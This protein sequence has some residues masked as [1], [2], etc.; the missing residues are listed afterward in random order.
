MNLFDLK[1]PQVIKQMNLKELQLLASEIRSFLLLN[2]PKTGGHLS[3]NLGVVELTIALHFVFDSPVD[4]IIFDV[5]HQ[6]YTHKI[7]TGRASLFETLRQMD[8]LSGFINYQESIHDQWESGHAGTAISAMTGVLMANYQQ[9][10]HTSVVAL[11]GDA[12]ISNGTAFEALNFLGSQKQYKGIIVLN[13]NEMSISKNVGSFS[14]LFARIRN[15][16]WYQGTKKTLG[17]ITPRFLDRFIFQT[18]RAVKSFFQKANIFEDL[19]YMYLGPVDGHNL[20]KLIA[21]LKRAKK[22]KKSVVL[23]V[24][25]EKG[26][27]HEKAEID[28]VGVFHGI[29]KPKEKV[30]SMISW[31]KAI[32]MILDELQQKYKINVIMPAMTVGAEFVEFAQKYPDRFVDVGIA[33]GHAAVFAASLAKQKEHVFLP[34]YATFAQRAFDQI[35]ND[36]A[37]PN[38]PV[39]IGIDRAGLVGEDGSTHQG[40]YD[41]SMFNL[42]P[43]IKIASPKSMQEAANIIYQAFMKP[44]GPVVIRYPKGQILEEKLTFEK[45]NY[46]W[47]ILK[48]GN[49]LVVLGYGS[50]MDKVVAKMDAEKMNGAVVYTTWIKPVDEK[51]LHKVLK[52]NNRVVVYEEQVSAGSLY[53]QILDFMAKHNYHNKIINIAVPNQVIEHGKYLDIIKRLNL[54]VNSIIEKIKEFSRQ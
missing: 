43:N 26:K 44:E 30:E 48:E 17:K 12:G 20:G 28:D 47:R 15:A 32:V 7:L 6:A 18:K 24:V 22:A 2:I 29:S 5:G 8:G 10:K 1:D 35:L 49:H 34:L 16:K 33:E 25:T 51:M 54:D 37:R 38:L 21:A 19:G 46:E 9:S 40:I 31:S 41:V 23:H 11:V 53:P 3:S 13:D 42:M 36:I 45:S 39:V 50:M 14:N 4:Q 27:G 52:D